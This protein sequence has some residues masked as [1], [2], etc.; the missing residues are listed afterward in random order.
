[1]PDN[2]LDQLRIK[3]TGLFGREREV[4]VCRQMRI[5]IRLDE[6]N[7]VGWRQPQVDARVTVDREQTIDAF[8]RLLDFANERGI[9]PFGEFIP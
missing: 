1:M 5:R 4:L 9:E 8:A 7:F 6:I 3:E 2:S